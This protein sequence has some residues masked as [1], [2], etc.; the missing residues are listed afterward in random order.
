[1]KQTIFSILVIALLCLSLTVAVVDSETLRTAG[2]RPGHPLY[3]LDKI[4]DNMGLSGE[5]RGI[6]AAL[7]HLQVSDERVAE[8]KVLA[9]AQ[10]KPELISEATT[11]AEKKAAKAETILTTTI[12]P[13]DVGTNAETYGEIRTR[14]S[15]RNVVLQSIIARLQTDDNPNNDRAIQGL[16]NALNHNKRI[17][18]ESETLKVKTDEILTSQGLRTVDELIS[19]RDPSKKSVPE[20]FKAN[21]QANQPIQVQTTPLTAQTGGVQRGIY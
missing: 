18:E 15:Q 12:S 6:N 4:F 9:E 5:E 2:W 17:S 1:M 16:Q 21:P 14:L 3:F 7:A 19:E 13:G 11:D 20:Q 10:A 8:A